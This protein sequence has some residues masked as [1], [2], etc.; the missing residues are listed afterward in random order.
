MEACSWSAGT[1]ALKCALTHALR[2]IRV[3]RVIRAIRAK[4]SKPPDNVL[5]MVLRLLR[6]N[7]NSVTNWSDAHLPQRPMCERR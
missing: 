2:V 5:D 7:D 4:S 6:E 1:K 3:I